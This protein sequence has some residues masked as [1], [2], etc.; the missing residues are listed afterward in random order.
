MATAPLAYIGG[1][2]EEAR[3]ANQAYQDA[4][5]KM[6]ES[7]DARKNRMFD[8]TMLAMAQGF[9]TPGKTGSF[10]E[11]LGNVA[12]NVRQAEEQAAKEEQASA[13]AGV[14]VAQMNLQLQQQLQRDKPWQQ[15]AQ[16]AAQPGGLP[17][18][19]A[20]G[21]AKPPDALQVVRSLGGVGEGTQ[22]PI[23]NPLPNKM[24]FMQDQRSKG[25][26]LSDAEKAWHE[27]V[28]KSIKVE[29]NFV[30]DT[31]NGYMY[32]MRP[33]VDVV[34]VP[35]STQA[36][37]KFPMTKSEAQQLDRLRRTD[38]AKADE[39]ER[40]FVA[41]RK[42][43]SASKAEEAGQTETQTLLAREESDRRKNLSA[44]AQAGEAILPSLS[45]ISEIASDPQMSG[46][47]GRFAGG[48]LLDAAVR[49]AEAGVGTQTFRLAANDLQNS[50][51]PLNLTPEQIEK[52]KLFA[53]PA[54][55]IQIAIAKATRGEGSTSDRERGLFASMGVSATT[56]PAK[57]ILMKSAG[58]AAKAEFDKKAYDLFEQSGMSVAQF[59]RSEQFKTLE[60]NYIDTLRKIVQSSSRP[61][62]SPAPAS[63][64]RTPVQRQRDDLRRRLEE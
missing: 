55:Q 19:P 21:E 51:T 33:E 44:A 11:S 57:V 28:S 5:K 7:L 1:D 42:S 20:T 18:K 6:M 8:P 13:E 46:V 41:G 56:D 36:G 60:N 10:G 49:M 37:Q 9:L 32:E 30:V 48:S 53:V 59:K 24:T 2:S 39:W 61:V 45:Q 43:A 58:L 40:K 14:K 23:S 4:L 35:L 63:G 3:A 27:L 62:V 64:G 12:G 29:G 34:D 38:P 54:G 15:Y 47:F 25:A 31:A 50:L 17:G 52:Y 16:G 26:S 22:I